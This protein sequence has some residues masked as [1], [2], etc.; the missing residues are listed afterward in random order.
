MT[1]RSSR[2]RRPTTSSFSE[3]PY[4]YRKDLLAFVVIGGVFWLLARRPVAP[5][6]R[7]PPPPSRR[8]APATFDIRD[9]ASI[10]RV[11]M[12]EILAARAAGNYVEFALDDGRRP[13]M[14]ASLARIESALSPHGFVRTHRSWLVNPG[15]VRGA[16]SPPAPATSASTSAAASPPHSPAA[17][18]RRWRG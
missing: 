1:R 16:D 2:R 6:T 17:T 9:G 18:P 12:G 10:L 7:P 13:L 5:A 11:A 8:L 3:L 4:E 14:R 15:R